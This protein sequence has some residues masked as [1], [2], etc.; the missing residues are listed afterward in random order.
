MSDEL[1]P[2]QDPDVLE[3]MYWDNDMTQKVL[4]EVNYFCTC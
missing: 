3:K 4:K 1:K 2:Y